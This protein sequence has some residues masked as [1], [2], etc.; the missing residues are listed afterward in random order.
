MSHLRDR[1]RPRATLDDCLYFPYLTMD[2]FFAL[3][4]IQFGLVWERSGKGA[5]FFGVDDDRIDL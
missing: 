3:F 4:R 5:E 2:S 1:P